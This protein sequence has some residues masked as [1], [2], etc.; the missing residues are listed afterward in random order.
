[1]QEADLEVIKEV[2]ESTI[3]IEFVLKADGFSA[4]DKTVSPL[5]LDIPRFAYIPLFIGKIRQAFSQINA[6]DDVWFE[7]NKTLLRWHYPIGFLY[8]IYGEKGSPW[9]LTVHHGPYQT[10]SAVWKVL[11]RCIDEDTI[12]HHFKN[13]V[14]QAHCMKYG[15]IDAINQLSMMDSDQMWAGVRTNDQ[16]RYWKINEKLFSHE[17]EKIEKMKIPIRFHYGER[18]VSQCAF[19]AKEGDTFQT[20]ATFLQAVIPD[21]FPAVPQPSHFAYLRHRVMVQGIRP[22]FDMTLLW[23]MRNLSHTDNFLYITISD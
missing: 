5:Y 20:L 14:K 9:Q 1:M 2:W 8:D 16:E 12:K 13:M 15:N 3:S 7:V 23:M 4:S 19:P 21:F 10:N 17:T 11:L 6:N 18:F 22:S